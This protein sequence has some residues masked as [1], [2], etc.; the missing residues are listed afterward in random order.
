M[1]SS[2]LQNSA[3]VRVGVVGV[4]RAENARYKPIRAVFYQISRKPKNLLQLF[5]NAGYF[6]CNQRQYCV[7]K[8]NR[9]FKIAKSVTNCHNLLQTVTLSSYKPLHFYLIIN[10]LVK[11]KNMGL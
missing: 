7:T 4:D 1:I 11:Y 9:I 2:I 6:L 3:L 10:Q 5:Q 8:C